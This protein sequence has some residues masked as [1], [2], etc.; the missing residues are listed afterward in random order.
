MDQPLRVDH[1]VD[2]G[3]LQVEQVVRLDHL[4]ALVHQRRGVDRDLR[5]H[6]PD[7]MRERLL[8]RRLRELRVRPAAERSAGSRQHHALEILPP[9]ATE[10]LR[11]RGVL[12]VDRHES[13][14]LALD[15][16]H[17]EL[18]ADDQALLVREREHLAA[19]QRRERRHEADGTDEGVQHHVGVGLSGE[20]LRGVGTGEDLHAP[21]LAEVRLE[22]AR[23]LLVGDR[24]VRRQELPDLA[25]Q[26]LVIGPCGEPDHP[27]AVGVVPDDV[28][29][30]RAH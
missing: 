6:L 22:V 11:E 17:H 16:I 14:R 4:E 2:R 29:G 10:T 23:R 12:G 5:P 7:R 21:E 26:E 28:Q 13:L 30:L 1:D 19:L 3:V 25:G 8:H 15:Q 20:H 24:D 18:A 27:E 9:L